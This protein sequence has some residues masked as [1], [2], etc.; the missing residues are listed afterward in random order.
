MSCAILCLDG[1]II[2][3]LDQD[4]FFQGFNYEL[5]YFLKWASDGRTTK[6][7]NTNQGVWRLYHKVFIIIPIHACAWCLHTSIRQFICLDCFYLLTECKIIPNAIGTWLSLIRFAWSDIFQG[8]RSTREAAW[9][10]GIHCDRFCIY[11]DNYDQ[12]HNMMWAWWSLNAFSI[13]IK[14]HENCTSRCSKV[15]HWRWPLVYLKQYQN[16]A[17]DRAFRVH[18]S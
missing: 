3:K 13:R 18:Y 8:D 2:M 4:H 6:W 11:E 14:C 5:T 15:A 9:R 1:A 7:L 10:T 16:D 12:Q 17:I